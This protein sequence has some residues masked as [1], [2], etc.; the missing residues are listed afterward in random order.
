[1]S[2][3]NGIYDNLPTFLLKKILAFLIVKLALKI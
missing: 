3:A 1:M 2:T